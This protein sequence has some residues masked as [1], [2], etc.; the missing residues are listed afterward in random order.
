MYFTCNRCGGSMGDPGEHSTTAGCLVGRSTVGAITFG[1][2]VWGS[3]EG[4]K[5]LRY[6]YIIQ[7]IR[8]Y[9][10]EWDTPCPDLAYRTKCRQRLFDLLDEEPVQK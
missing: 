6:G 4:R 1:D 10:K 3:E 9:R 2:T 7:A 8:E 5:L